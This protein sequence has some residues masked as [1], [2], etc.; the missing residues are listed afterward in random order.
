MS[1]TSQVSNLEK[2]FHRLEYEVFLAGE[3]S[4][5]DFLAWLGDRLVHVYGESPNIDFVQA[6][7]RRAKALRGCFSGRRKPGNRG[8]KPDA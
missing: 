6:C 2:R 5:P 7:H 1:A 3:P 4:L 8:G